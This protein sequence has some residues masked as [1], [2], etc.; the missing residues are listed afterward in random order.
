MRPYVVRTSA[1]PVETA[2]RRYMAVSVRRAPAISATG[3]ADGVNMANW[4]AACYRL[5]ARVE[6]LAAH[7]AILDLGTCTVEEA[8]T[9]LQELF[10]YLIEHGLRIRAG[11]GPTP[12]VAQLASRLVVRAAAQQL[13]L[14]SITDAPAFL[15]LIP[16]DRLLILA[17]PD[18]ISMETVGRLRHCGVR[19]LGQLARLDELTLRRQF[20]K[21]GASLAALAQGRSLHVFRPTPPAPT[22]RFGLRAADPFTTDN[23]F[24]QLP[25]LARGV[26]E[27]LHEQRYEA[28]SIT[29]IIQWASGERTRLVRALRERVHAPR[30]LTQE[31]ARL[32]VPALKES[33]TEQIDSI[34]CVLSDL[35]RPEPSQPLLFP[36]GQSALSARRAQLRALADTLAQRRQRPVLLASRRIAEHAIFGE[37]GYDI[38]PLEHEMDT[39]SLHGASATAG[40]TSPQQ[41][42]WQ[43]AP[44][45]L[46]WW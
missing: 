35:G 13:S 39:A 25:R 6:L 40:A 18:A 43:D 37:D 23:M 21:I 1:E 22:L 4:V 28:G 42:R 10:A 16:I 44:L 11:V 38:V 31:L 29:V 36:Q 26:A 19:T 41:N 12:V 5:T 9:A 2:E 32:I 8:R 34:R 30:L 17:A 14:V 27:V 33:S 15:K 3:D 7:S 46:H 24:R 20:G 45:R